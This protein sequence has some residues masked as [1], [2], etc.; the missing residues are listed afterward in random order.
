MVSS[1][2]AI[3]PPLTLPFAY[4]STFSCR[5]E[6]KNL[7]SLLSIYSHLP[8]C[9]PS[10]TISP[11]FSNT[12]INTRRN[13][14][15]FFSARFCHENYISDVPSGCFREIKFSSRLFVCSYLISQAP[16]QRYG[17]NHLWR[18][19]FEFFRYRWS[20]NLYTGG[21]RESTLVITIQ[22]L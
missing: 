21:P 8:S 19:T 3:H 18:P 16:I 9:L 15:E 6:D 13:T 12:N 10:L 5:R 20:F 11:N 4:H 7:V 22:E 14:S 2:N 1:P 17:A